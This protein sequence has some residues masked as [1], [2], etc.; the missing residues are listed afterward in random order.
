V[1]IRVHR[2]GDEDCDDEISRWVMTSILA[3]SKKLYKSVKEGQNPQVN[4]ASRE[5][6]LS[7]SMLI[8]KTKDESALTSSSVLTSVAKVK[9]SASGG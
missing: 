2:R 9:A 7:Q 3:G 4:V 5:K 8:R 1:Y 6:K